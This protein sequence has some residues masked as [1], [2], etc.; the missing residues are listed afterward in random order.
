MN[1]SSNGNIFRVTTGHRWIPAQR[2]VTRS[3][4]VFVDLRLIKR[5][6]KQLWSWWFGT[7]SRPLWRHCNDACLQH[8]VHH[9][10]AHSCTMSTICTPTT[11]S[12]PPYAYPQLHHAMST[13]C[14]ARAAPCPTYVAAVKWPEPQ[15]LRIHC[16]PVKLPWIFPL[17]INGAPGN[18]QGNLTA[19]RWP[20]VVRYT[21][22][23]T[24]VLEVHYTQRCALLQGATSVT[25]SQGLTWKQGRKRWQ[26]PCMVD[27]RTSSVTIGQGLTDTCTPSAITGQGLTWKQGS[28]WAEVK[29][30]RQTRYLEYSR[31]RLLCTPVFHAWWHH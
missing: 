12:C 24:C 20:P 1:T 11:A 16:I 5:L 13:I 4:D 28:R 14:A 27:T 29:E 2:P 8:H 25:V 9:M 26:K 31:P 10:R 30:T 23:L 7:P 17:K 15:L 18:I 21:R 6:S 3:F 22:S 19:L